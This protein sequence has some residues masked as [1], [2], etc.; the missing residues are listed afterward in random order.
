MA[1]WCLSKREIS[2]TGGS[3]T[4]FGL[5]KRINLTPKGILIAGSSIRRKPSMPADDITISLEL[6]GFKVTQL[7][8]EPDGYVM[9]VEPTSY[10]AV[11]PR[12]GR[13]S[14]D[15]HDGS[16]R[17]VWDLPLLGYPVYL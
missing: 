4:I 15:Y 10:G 12:C 8:S 11:C 6:P 1:A 16:E 17:T 14:A 9:W 13:T 3:L 7:T 2:N 5:C